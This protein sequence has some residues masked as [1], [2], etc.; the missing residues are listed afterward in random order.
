MGCVFGCVF[1]PTVV[2]PRQIATFSLEFVALRGVGFTLRNNKVKNLCGGAWNDFDASIVR[3]AFCYWN[4][5]RNRYN[6]VGFRISQEG[7][8]YLG[9]K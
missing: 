5:P 1:R 4:R 6:D 8:L 2:C 9:Q 3:A 7:W